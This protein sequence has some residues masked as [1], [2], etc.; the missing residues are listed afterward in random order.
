MKNYRNINRIQ[1]F[2]FFLIAIITALQI[3]AFF[4]L[5]GK[6]LY[7]HVLYINFILVG[8]CMT[9]LNHLKMRYFNN[10]LTKLIRR[11]YDE[12]HMYMFR[13]KDSLYAASIV[14]VFA[15]ILLE[16]ILIYKAV[17]V[18]HTLG[19]FYAVVY[20]FVSAAI[21]GACITG[22]KGVI[23]ASKTTMSA[24]EHYNDDFTKDYKIKWENDNK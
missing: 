15:D 8:A 3:F 22:Y 10:C 18:N 13:A 9:I 24:A 16:A 14:Y 12:V 20:M 2:F 4:K 1:T 7:P 5:I 19:V 17:L 11:E 23:D 6:G 21:L